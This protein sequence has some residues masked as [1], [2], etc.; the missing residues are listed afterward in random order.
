MSQD[1]YFNNLTFVWLSRFPKDFIYT[2]YLLLSFLASHRIPADN[3]H[4]PQ[5]PP[6]PVER[7]AVP[8]PS[9]L[10]RPAVSPP[11]RAEL[12]SNRDASVELTPSVASPPA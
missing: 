6:V 9:R 8:Q 1:Q 2:R 7:E 11:C 10:R 5:H 12:S 4:S 3:Q